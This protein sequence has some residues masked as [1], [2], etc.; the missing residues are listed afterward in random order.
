[1]ITDICDF[2]VRLPQERIEMFGM[3][4][5]KKSS[6]SNKSSSY[7]FNVN[8][9]MQFNYGYTIKDASSEFMGISW[10]SCP[11]TASKFIA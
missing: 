11:I 6:R 7:D 9:D 1:M 4:I 2:A 5:Q 3:K 10:A 8:V